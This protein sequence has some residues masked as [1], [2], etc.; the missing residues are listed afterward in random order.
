ME[1]EAQKGEGTDIIV[2]TDFTFG[3]S[4]GEGICPASDRAS[5]GRCLYLSVHSGV[6]VPWGMSAWVSSEKP[7]TLGS[8]HFPA[9]ELPSRFEVF[10]FFF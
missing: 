6:S 4:G 7:V 10:F 9:T 5:W 3:Q 2:N 1:T 8:E